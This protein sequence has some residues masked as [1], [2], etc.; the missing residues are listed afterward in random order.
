[1]K[2]LL[3]L[4][5]LISILFLFSCFNNIK[6]IPNK[7]EDTLMYKSE[8]RLIDSSKIV[9]KKFFGYDNY[10][11][12]AKEKSLTECEK[13]KETNNQQ[14][15]SCVLFNYGFTEYGKKMVDE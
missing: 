10:E 1:M 4:A 13:Y 9:I 5:S 7:G 15:F 6:I 2:N 3:R 11:N 12:I 14:L 8:T